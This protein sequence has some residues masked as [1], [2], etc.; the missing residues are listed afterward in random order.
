MLSYLISDAAIN[1][2]GAV[3]EILPVPLLLT[4][5]N[6]SPILDK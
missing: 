4:L 3:K 1:A 5:I 6:F 2:F